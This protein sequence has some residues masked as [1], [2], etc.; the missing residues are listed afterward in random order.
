MKPTRK[1]WASG[2]FLLAVTLAGAAA[3][4]HWRADLWAVITSQQ[5]R[6]AFIQWVRSKGLWGIVVFLSLQVVQVVVAVL[7]G[8][9][10]ELMAGALFGPVGGLAICLLGILLGSGFIYAAMK[11]LGAQAA[12]AQALQKYRFLQTPERCRQALYLLFFLPGTPK[13]MLT[14]AG[15]FLPVP[16]REFFFISTL[17]RI[18]SVLTSTV[19]GASLAEGH[20]WLPAVIFVMTGAAGLLCI[21]YEDRIHRW[22]HQKAQRLHQH[23][24]P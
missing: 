9:P 2:L 19:A 4:W 15:P 17:A 8:E 13:D 12:P 18:P 16:A 5:A 1:Q 6:D 3:I 23:K 10:V 22:L 7:P 11:L 21:H 14:Y 20:I 24:N